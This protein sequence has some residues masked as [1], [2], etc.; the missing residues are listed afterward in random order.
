MYL[1][2]NHFAVYLK[3]TQHCKSLH[4]KSHFNTVNHF[5]VNHTSIKKK[6]LLDTLYPLSLFITH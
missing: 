2:L 6:I 1:K 3:L 4:C 5:I